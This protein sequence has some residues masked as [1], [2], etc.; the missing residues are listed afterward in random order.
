MV[1]LTITNWRKK[2]VWL[3]AALL[4]G[5]ALLLGQSSLDHTG[6][7]LPASGGVQQ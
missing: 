7:S 1:V 6:Q 2:L 3:L 4:V 5:T